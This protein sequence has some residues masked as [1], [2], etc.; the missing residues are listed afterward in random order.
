MNG[1][2][3]IAQYTMFNVNDHYTNHLL[4]D[5]CMQDSKELIFRLP[6]QLRAKFIHGKTPES[7][8]RTPV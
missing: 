5:D 7:D 8:E 3:M 6:Q 4:K 2:T 1:L